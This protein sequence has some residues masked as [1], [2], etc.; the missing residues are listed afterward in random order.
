MLRCALTVYTM[1][2]SLTGVMKLLAREKCQSFL[3]TGKV[4]LLV[5]GNIPG[6]V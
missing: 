1:K 4:T 6:S 3:K 2:L 5:V